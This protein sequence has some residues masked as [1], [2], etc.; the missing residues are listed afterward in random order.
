MKRTFLYIPLLLAIVLA[1]CST[2][3]T[4]EQKQADS[5]LFKQIHEYTLNPDGSMVYRY[6]HKRLYNTYQSFHRYYGE[7]FVSFNPDYQTLKVNLSKTTMADGKVVHSPENAFNEILPFHASLAPAYNHLRDMVIT[8]VGLEIGAVVE[9]DYTIETKAGYVP[10]FSEDIIL[11]QTSPVK[12]LEIIVRV[13][14]GHRL[15]NKV[16]NAPANL[17]EKRKTEGGFQVV[18]WHATE[19]PPIANEALQSD[20]MADYHRL[21][22][23]E[24][25]LEQVIN[26]Y[27]NT[28]T[29]EINDDPSLDKLLND[30]KEGWDKVEAIRN[31]VVSNINTYRVPPRN[32]GYQFR[33]PND[34]WKSNGGTEGDKVI[35]LSALLKKAG[36]D[37]RPAF[38]TYSHLIDKEIG[39]ASAFDRYYVAVEFDGETRYLSAI[40]YNSPKSDSR[41]VIVSAEQLDSIDAEGKN[42][43]MATS[44]IS[45]LSVDAKGFV[46]GTGTLAMNPYDKDGG[47]L[48]G[49][50]RNCVKTEK[51]SND[52]E[53]DIFSVTISNAKSEAMGVY[54]S[55]TLPVIA[56]G[57]E[58]VRTGELPSQRITPLHL[59]WTVDERYDFTISAPD[60]FTFVNP[61]YDEQLENG[62]GS[63][64]IGHRVLESGE[65]HIERQLSIYQSVIPAESY[66]DFRE[67]INI[68]KDVN[69][70]RFIVK[71]K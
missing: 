53:S 64:K 35:L 61:G 67:L 50:P 5:V 24:W 31:Y 65:L 33:L 60:G 68:W 41:M 16:L 40:G 19:V 9:L 70:N 37:A 3:L 15:S 17:K 51:I 66:N 32:C 55:F 2:P 10:C 6:Y 54:F 39:C 12:D 11:N 44:L 30:K 20:G 52:N 22:F 23:S 25:D 38:G 1:S 47:M 4:E 57:F 34:V 18:K 21:M 49:I 43:G 26:Y 29:K 46:S 14:K 28:F 62:V 58:W 59:P 71:S 69:L 45:T 56:Q 7:T 63:V 27:K 13:P 42:T 48:G 36:F 8:H